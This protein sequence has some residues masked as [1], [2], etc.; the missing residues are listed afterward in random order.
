M[1]DELYKRYRP[2][3]F[4]D[5]V[6]Q[7]AAVDTLIQM[8]KTNTVPHTLLFTGPSGTG[9]T[10]LARILR[11]KLGCSDFDFIEKNAAETRGIEMVREI[12]QQLG[13]SPLNGPCKVWLL[14]EVHSLTS[15][16]QNS[17]LK[18]LEDTPS[19]VYFLLATTDPQKLKKTI[20]TRC[21][22]I[23]CRLLTHTELETLVRRV[24]EEEGKEVGE[25]AILKLLDVADGSARKALVILHQVIQQTTPKAQLEAVES[26]DSSIE[27]IDIFRAL[28][29][30]KTTWPAMAEVLN[31]VREEPERLRQLVLACCTT[32]LLNDKKGGA[33]ASRI[34]DEF[35]D[36][37]FDCGRAGLVS[38]CR[39]VILDN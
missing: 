26:S 30:E 36:H 14:D 33:R 4:K 17:F 20:V 7:K 11:Q 3:S 31:G 28:M 13:T 25:D 2:T 15:D 24:I 19:H 16:A 1:S 21:T 18:T 39:H 5:V 9:K 22:E 10:T 27:S 23:K 32:S 8:G 38:A 29:S 37:W 34:I 12:M 6:G 35:R